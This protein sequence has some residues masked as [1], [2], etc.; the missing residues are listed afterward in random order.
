VCSTVESGPTNSGSVSELRTSPLDG[1]CSRT[2]S[3]E[4]T[5]NRYQ[6]IVRHAPADRYRVFEGDKLLGEVSRVDLERG[7]DLLRLPELSTNVRALDILNLVRKKERLLSAGRGRAE[8]RRRKD[9]AGEKTLNS[10]DQRSFLDS[11]CA[12]WCG[13]PALLSPGRSRPTDTSQRRVRCP[14]RER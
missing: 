6:L 1:S 7:F 4:R 12:K 5:L 9:A 8:Q 10:P 3:L 14:C 11:R 13:S 2:G